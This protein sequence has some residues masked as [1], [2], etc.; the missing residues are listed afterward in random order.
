MR[1]IIVR[2]NKMEDIMKKIIITV[3]LFALLLT[4]CEQAKASNEVENVEQSN[5]KDVVV[6]SSNDNTN[7]EVTDSSEDNQTEEEVVY[8]KVGT[9]ESINGGIVM[10]VAGCIAEDYE[11]GEEEAKKF[12]VGETVEVFEE[13]D[14]VSLKSFLNESSDVRFTSMGGLI[15]QVTGELITSTEESIVILVNEEEM[16]FEIFDEVL[17]EIGDTVTIE[18]SEMGEN[19]QFLAI[20]NE[21]TK[22]STKV[23]SVDRSEDGYLVLNCGDEEISFI[24]SLKGSV[25]N[26]N[27]SEISAG[28]EVDLYFDIATL[29]LPSKINPKRVIKK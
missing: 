28:D 15:L 24:A 10:V 14:G 3:T 4:G 6:T 29:S 13:E 18:Y 16:K 9:V 7:E 11:I 21:T 26:F 22:T 8:N 2:L 1:L 27:Y 25:T 5:V 23:I 17:A 19:Q 20:Y 12:Y